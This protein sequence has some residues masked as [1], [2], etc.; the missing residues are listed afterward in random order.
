MTV[1]GVPWKVAA[2]AGVGAFCTG[3]TVAMVIGVLVVDELAR[4]SVNL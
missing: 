2:A 3:F 1:F 4:R